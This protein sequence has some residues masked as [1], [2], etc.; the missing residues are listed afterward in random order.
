SKEEQHIAGHVAALIWAIWQNR[1]ATV[2][3]NSR[4]S[5]EQVGGHAFQLWQNWFEAQK[6]RTQTQQQQTVQHSAQ[7]T[8]PHEGWIKINVDAGFFEQQTTTTTACCIRNNNGEFMGALTRKYN[9]RMSIMEGEGV[10]LLDAAQLAIHKGWNFVV[11]ESDSQNLVNA[12][13]SKDGG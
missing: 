1:N 11:F 10:A 3:D 4:N 8:K 9:S 2:W 13:K 6:F 5:P 12:I 7:W